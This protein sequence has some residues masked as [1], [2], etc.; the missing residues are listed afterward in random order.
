[1]VTGDFER[2]GDRGA[3]DDSARFTFSANGGAEF[4]SVAHVVVATRDGSGDR[5]AVERVGEFVAHKV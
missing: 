1:L 5:D 2:V 4:F 3:G